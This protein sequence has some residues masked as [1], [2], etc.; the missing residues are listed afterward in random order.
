M[1]VSEL[2]GALL[3]YWVAQC[4][5][6]DRAPGEW[7][8]LVP[9][10]RGATCYYVGKD[11]DRRAI[12]SPSSRWEQGGPIIE[13]ERIIIAPAGSPPDGDYEWRAQYPK[14]PRDEWNCYGPTPLVAAMRAFVLDRFG[15]EVEDIDA[16]LVRANQ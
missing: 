16:P 15:E 5:P 2:E 13:R 6:P 7:H 14:H 1:K 10:S 4:N 12:Y 8:R 3:D 9:H 11:G